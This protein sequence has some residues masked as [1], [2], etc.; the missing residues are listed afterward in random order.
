MPCMKKVCKQNCATVHWSAT[1][2]ERAHVVSRINR[3]FCP[4]IGFPD[5]LGMKNVCRDKKAAVY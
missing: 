4:P 2:N 5:I 3:W 1:R